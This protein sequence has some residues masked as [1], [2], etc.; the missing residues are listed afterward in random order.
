MPHAIISGGWPLPVEDDAPTGGAPAVRSWANVYRFLY[1]DTSFL[2]QPQ[3]ALFISLLGVNSELGTK[4]TS[5]IEI[6]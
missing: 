1:T 4:L 2:L 5:T 6:A 3:L